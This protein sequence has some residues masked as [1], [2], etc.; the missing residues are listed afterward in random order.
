MSPIGRAVRSLCCVLPLPILLGCGSQSHVASPAL[1]G[2]W[3]IVGDSSFG[4]FP[5]LSFALIENGS[6]LYARGVFLAGCS[7]HAGA[8]GGGSVELLG[9]VG[10]DGSFVLTQPASSSIRLDGDPVQVTV[11]GMAP[12]GN[13]GWSGTYSITTPAGSSGCLLDEAGAFTAVP[14]QHVDGTYSGTLRED[15]LGPGKAIVSLAVSQGAPVSQTVA[16]GQTYWRLPLIGTLSVSGIPC[17]THGSTQTNLISF[18][19]GSEIAIPFV[20][21]DGSHLSLVGN[22][23]DTSSASLNVIALGAFGGPCSKGYSGTLTRQ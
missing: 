14:F 18:V 21:D 9:E 12:V 17:F 13:T 16:N 1:T 6:D 3:N 23:A 7:N 2:N 10:P 22:L 19:A 4:H 11:Q 8:G 5:S 15:N 20:M